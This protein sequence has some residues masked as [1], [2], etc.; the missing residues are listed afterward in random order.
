MAPCYLTLQAEIPA[1]P[2]KKK[3]VEMAQGK[4]AEILIHTDRV[5]KVR[6]KTVLSRFVVYSTSPVF[7]TTMSELLI[8]YEYGMHFAQTRTKWLQWQQGCVV[9]SL[10]SM[11]GRCPLRKFQGIER[12]RLVFVFFVSLFS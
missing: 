5:T 3:T 7:E 11:T 8:S 12:I 10:I 6:K 1:P 4:W 2:A 9:C